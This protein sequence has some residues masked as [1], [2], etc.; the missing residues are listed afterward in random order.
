MAKEA[1]QILTPE[2]LGLSEDEFQIYTAA[3]ARRIITL[4]E[5]ELHTKKKKVPEAIAKLQSK[6]FIKSIP[7]KIERYFGVPPLSIIQE[8]TLTFQDSMNRIYE[9]VKTYLDQTLAQ[10]DTEIVKSTETIVQATDSHTNVLKENITQTDEEL[11]G[12]LFENL[13]GIKEVSKNTKDTLLDILSSLQNEM[14]ALIQNTSKK[15]SESCDATNTKI[16]SQ[17]SQST[18]AIIEALESEKTQCND[19]ITPLKESTTQKIQNC[20]DDVNTI[21]QSIDNKIDDALTVSVEKIRT[22]ISDLRDRF[23]QKINKNFDQLME[24]PKS[25]G[26]ITSVN[27]STQKDEFDEDLKAFETRI[28]EDFSKYIEEYQKDLTE[29]ITKAFDKINFIFGQYKTSVDEITS[30]YVTNVNLSKQEFGTAISTFESILQKTLIDEIEEYQV[31]LSEKRDGWIEDLEGIIEALHSNSLK[32]I[33]EITQLKNNNLIEYEK[34]VDE[35]K[36]THENE[37]TTH[38]K[39]YRDGLAKLRTQTENTITQFSDEFVKELTSLFQSISS[40]MANRFEEYK[41]TATLVD[42]SIK[43]TFNELIEDSRKFRRELETKVYSLLS[44]NKEAFSTNSKIIQ[45]EVNQILDEHLKNAKDDYEQLIEFNNSIIATHSEMREEIDKNLV[46]NLSKVI[47]EAANERLETLD[48]LHKYLDGGVTHLATTFNNEVGAFL[49]E[50]ET[51]RDANIEEY[52]NTSNE[53]KNTVSDHLRTEFT[54]FDQIFG[55][56]TSTTTTTINQEKET[57]DNLFTTLQTDLNNKISTFQKSIQKESAETK[58]ELQTL[59]K[60]ESNEEKEIYKKYNIILKEKMNEL[61]GKLGLYLDDVSLKINDTLQSQLEEI[62]PELIRVKKSI[63]TDSES[64]LRNLSESVQEILTKISTDILNFSSTFDQIAVFFSG[65]TNSLF[66]ELKTTIKNIESR[67]SSHIESN[68]KG[69]IDYLKEYTKDALETSNDSKT[70]VMNEIK[71]IKTEISEFFENLDQNKIMESKELFDKHIERYTNLIAQH[72]EQFDKN[73]EESLTQKITVLKDKQ[74]EFKETISTEVSEKIH[75]PLI[76]ASKNSELRIITTLQNFTNMMGSLAK[77]FADNLQLRFKEFSDEYQTSLKEFSQIIDKQMKELKDTTKSIDKYS[78][79]LKAQQ[80]E[81]EKIEIKNIENEI[82]Q[83]TGEL[84]NT[85]A[86]TLKTLE[87]SLLRTLEEGKTQVIDTN[88]SL[89]EDI[90]VA[91]S[92]TH[93]QLTNELNAVNEG[94]ISNFQSEID[95]L[96]KE[97]KNLTKE[98]DTVLTTHLTEYDELLA[99]QVNKITNIVEGIKGLLVEQVDA[100]KIASSEYIGT[101]KKLYSENIAATLKEITSAKTEILEDFAAKTQSLQKEINNR[102]TDQISILKKDVTT[103]KQEHK[104]WIANSKR[105]HS[106]AINALKK[107]F[108]EDFSTIIEHT[109]SQITEAKKSVSDSLLGNILLYELNNALAIGQLTQIQEN[110]TSQLIKPV[111]DA[112]KDFINLLLTQESDLDTFFELVRQEMAKLLDLNKETQNKSLDLFEDALKN[113]IE[114]NDAEIENIVNLIRES[115]LELVDFHLTTSNERRAALREEINEQLSKVL[116]EVNSIAL[117]KI[118]TI[119]TTKLRLSEE[120]EKMIHTTQEDTE[121]IHTKYLQQLEEKAH[122]AKNEILST[123][124]NISETVTQEI[125]TVNNEIKNLVDEH[126]HKTSDMATL[127]DTEITTTLEQTIENFE[128]RLTKLDEAILPI[129]NSRAQLFEEH[130]QS[131]EEFVTNALNMNLGDLLQFVSEIQELSQS[132]TEKITNEFTDSVNQ[133]NEETRNHLGQKTEEKIEEVAR[134]VNEIGEELTTSQ[135]IIESTKNDLQNGLQNLSLQQSQNIDEFNTTI[136]TKLVGNVKVN[137]ENLAN[138]NKKIIQE[139]NDEIEEIIK[140]TENYEVILKDLWDEIQAILSVGIASEN[141]WYLIGEQLNDFSRA[142][143]ERT[144]RNLTII[145]PNITDVSL[146]TIKKLDPSVQVLI[147]TQ[148]EL[149]TEDEKH[150]LQELYQLGNVRVKKNSRIE[151]SV[152]SRD[153]EEVLIAPKGVETLGIISED[154]SYV[155]MIN[156]IIRPEVVRSAGAIS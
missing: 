136:K 137:I 27:I 56:F 32:V 119:E 132:W 109:D 110:T 39:E 45:E 17:S 87:E 128:K 72:F 71:E 65:N 101:T 124:K 70:Q 60:E 44:E 57:L 127:V 8:G 50:I 35:I 135:N 122:T 22:Q 106:K 95:R 34:N 86:T 147:I 104:K 6:G 149:E 74:T 40:H 3:L 112:N 51:D 66:E 100:T 111:T 155:A 156:K 85:K 16:T 19:L 144:Q 41:N 23:T 15:I 25:L 107:E 75:R 98:L 138:V 142:A 150:A 24:L 89:K 79:E 153:N 91:Y 78:K 126:S 148:P 49:R 67:F 29:F 42:K 94:I 92:K 146:D 69:T 83:Y 13:E 36:L 2:L 120:M 61:I 134:I 141:T 47:N 26:E 143:I 115:A 63:K 152:L 129:R 37:V 20:Q 53:F 140:N 58:K 38:V 21:E 81:S 64:K 28:Q 55:N 93:E 12:I 131:L 114:T 108:S 99:T 1:D 116:Q 96:N 7:G 123:V 33:E 9:E 31:K 30:E 84:H 117:S 103:L 130:V 102:F 59:L 73:I 18:E 113:K 118:D 62:E 88:Q 145:T 48:K 43:Q 133:L 68:L 4:G 105:Q 125:T 151:Y 97:T 5:I 76:Q 77:G 82:M 139:T 121:G 154:P 10:L 80:I 54:T 52:K 46:E 11:T 90:E 14:K